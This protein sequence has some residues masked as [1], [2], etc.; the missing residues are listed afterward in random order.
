[1]DDDREDTWQERAQ[2]FLIG[3]YPGPPVDYVLAIAAMLTCMVVIGIWAL[4]QL[5]F[6]DLA[7]AVLHLARL[8]LP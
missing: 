1:M 3:D 8:L 2:A 5:P 4:L 6:E 7:R